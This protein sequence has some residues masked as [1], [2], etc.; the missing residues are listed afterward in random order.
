MTIRQHTIA[1]PY[2]VGPVHC[3]SMEVGGQLVLFDTGPPTEIAK[4]YL[5]QNLDLATLEYVFVTHCHIDHYGLAFWLEQETGAKI[6]IPY[7]DWLKINN[8]DERLERIL[9][10]LKEMGFTD[11]CLE[12]S[13]KA[14]PEKM[15]FPPFPEK[16]RIIEEDFPAHLGF[17]YLSCPGHSQSD[18]VFAG[19]DWAVT[20]DVLLRGVF[21][22]PLL[23]VDLD[24][25]KRFRNY[26][27]YCTTLGNLATLREK[28]IFPG[29][30]KRVTGVDESILFYVGKMLDRIE[31]LLP[32]NGYEHISRIVEGIFGDLYT[33]P[34]H[35]YL[36]AS[37]IAFMQDFLN[38]PQALRQALEEI[39]LFGV[40]EEPFRRVTKL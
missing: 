34:F 20:G 37:E 5:L 21:Q 10:L 25:G 2:M 40:V 24:T 17:E 39:G 7:R 28:K 33:K 27:A 23:D 14:I 12:T 9:D 1:T 22:S 4:Q 6:Y 15:L 36:K 31:T 3:Y 8:H 26:D 13:R 16:I 35:V 30:R 32:L 29:H 18:L 19:P 38:K 11:E